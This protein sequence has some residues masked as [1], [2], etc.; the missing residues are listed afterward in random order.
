MMHKV[1]NDHGIVS[2][3]Y[4]EGKAGRL[5]RAAKACTAAGAAVTLAVGRRRAGAVLGGALLAAGSALTRFGV[6]EA[7][8]ESARDPKYTVVPQRERIAARAAEQEH[9]STVTR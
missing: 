5:L 7:G 9:S 4:H 3:P 6:Y 2:E 1:E 8:M